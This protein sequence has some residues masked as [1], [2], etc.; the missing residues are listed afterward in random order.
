VFKN[1][2]YGDQ[3]IKN[4]SKALIAEF[5]SGFSERSVWQYR[6]FFQIFPNCQLR[7]Q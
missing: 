4:V 5:E 2:N 3:V 7:D 1:T 6:Q